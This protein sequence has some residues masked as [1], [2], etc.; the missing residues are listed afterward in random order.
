MTSHLKDNLEYILAHSDLL[1]FGESG[2][3]YT[4][5]VLRPDKLIEL[6][7]IDINALAFDAMDEVRNLVSE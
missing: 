4:L 5:D 1:Q 2:G 6:K 7:G 3:V